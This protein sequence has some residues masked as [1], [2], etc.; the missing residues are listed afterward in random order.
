MQTLYLIRHAHTVWTPEEARPLSAQGRR[1]AERIVSVLEGAAIFAIYASTAR[2]VQQTVT[3]LAAARQI[4]IHPAPE[5][6]ERALGPILSEASFL[7]AVQATWENPNFAL[8]GGET[9]AAAQQRAISFLTGLIHQNIPGPV[10]LATHGNLLA[11]ILQFFDPGINFDFWKALTMPDLYEL[12][13][14]E[15]NTATYRRLWLDADEG[16]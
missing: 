5:L 8:P 2:R 11:L 1:Q 4:P 10:V 13:V 7:Q 15:G 12:R 9:N 14:T 6:R 3:P 16:D